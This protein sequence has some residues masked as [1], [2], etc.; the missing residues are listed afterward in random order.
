VA[1]ILTGQ[2][3]DNA[4]CHQSTQKKTKKKQTHMSF[5]PSS[6][7]NQTRLGVG[8]HGSATAC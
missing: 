8:I 2:T 4:N 6:F 1:A 5:S 3:R 7:P